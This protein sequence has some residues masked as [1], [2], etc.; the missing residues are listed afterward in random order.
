M[1]GRTEILFTPLQFLARL[2]DLLAPPRKHRHRYYGV[3]APRARLRP[4]V[5]ATAGPAG[6]VL[7]ELAAAS[8]AMGLSETPDKRP[9]SRSWAMLLASIY[10]NRALQCPRCGQAMK[11]LA[12][13][14]EKKVIERI[15]HHLGEATTPP[16]VL[17]ARSP[18][19]LAMPFAQTTGPVT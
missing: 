8:K 4:V 6:T 12:F 16:G 10:E 19:Q 13:I 1:D 7:Q 3:L 15:L 2:V 9:A 11:I 5:T 14:L 17:P 18:P